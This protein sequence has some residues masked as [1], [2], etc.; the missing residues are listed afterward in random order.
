[1]EALLA[2]GADLK[3]KNKEGKTPFALAKMKK[4]RKVLSILKRHGAAE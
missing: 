4:N 2:K 1:V 3:A